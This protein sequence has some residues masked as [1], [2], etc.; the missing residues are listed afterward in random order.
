MRI[1]FLGLA[2][3][4]VIAFI[5]FVA[6]DGQYY[7]D[8]SALYLELAKNLIE[9]HRFVSPS[10][11]GKLVPEV[12]R[13]PG[14]PLFLAPFVALNLNFYWI[15]GAQELIYLLAV[16]LFWQ[17]GRVLLGER[18]TRLGVVFLLLEPGGFAYPKLILSETV[19]LFF[20]V[21]GFLALGHYLHRKRLVLI[22]LAGV[23]FGLGAWVRPAILYFPVAVALVLL[24]L[25]RRDRRYWRHAAVFLFCFVLIIAPWLYRNHQQFG[26]FFMTGQQSNMFANY[27]VPIVWEAVKGIPFWQAQE[28][29]RQKV[30]A[31][32]QK[33]AEQQDRPLS[34]VE[35]FDLQQ[36]RAVQELLHYP[37]AYLQQWLFGILKTMNG[38]NLTELYHNFHYRENRLHYF[39]VAATNFFER[40]WIFITNQDKPVLI[41]V[42]FRVVIS[43]LALLGVFFIVA[44]KNVFL[45]L[46][47]LA[48]FYFICL[49]GPMG[50]SRF[51]FPVEVFWF[52]QAVL[53]YCWLLIKTG[54]KTNCNFLNDSNANT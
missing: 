30:R 32:A 35:Y 20:F 34:R 22:V 10:D 8:D 45:W 28:Q 18:M 44:R 14:Y 54:E 36:K 4:H 11:S 2:G 26:R 43:A 15:A 19:F 52:A 23:L 3:L 33:Q 1:V 7:S 6:M 53:G 37:A 42:L 24:F 46:L 51:R 47:L 17:Y 48:N 16:G 27:H 50:Y 31:A 38:V 5:L 39:D 40:V 9:Q 25:A 21:S 13:T 49:P 12:F 41:L 29:M